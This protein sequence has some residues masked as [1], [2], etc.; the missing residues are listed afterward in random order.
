MA[1]FPGLNHQFSAQLRM[2]QGPR[3]MPGFRQVWSTLMGYEK[4]GD[5]ID[6]NLSGS[7]Y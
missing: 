7:V 3:Q 6:S 4:K 5:L 2:Q 1:V